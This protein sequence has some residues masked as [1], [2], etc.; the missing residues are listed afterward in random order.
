MKISEK[1]DGDVT[2]LIL[3]GDM[4]NVKIDIHPTIKKLIEDGRKKV[5]VDI[6][7]VKWFASTALGSLMASY[8]SLKAAEGEMKIARASRKIYSL[9][10]QMKLQEIFASYETVDE[11]VEAFKK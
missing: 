1:Q 7:K 2:I 11:A 6:G 4:I 9:F 3:S 10:Y 5:V 8:S